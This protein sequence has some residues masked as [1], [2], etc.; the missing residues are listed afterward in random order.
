MKNFHNIKKAFIITEGIIKTNS[1]HLGVNCGRCNFPLLKGD[2]W[3]HGPNKIL[4]HANCFSI[5]YE[6]RQHYFDERVKENIKKTRET[7][8]QNPQNFRKKVFDEMI[9]N[10][11]SS[12]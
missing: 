8:N 1:K 4:Y 5:E 9:R 7:Q 10:A 2:K 6:S 12:L 3:A 11:W